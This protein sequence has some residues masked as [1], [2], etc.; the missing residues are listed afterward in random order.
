MSSQQSFV[1]YVINNLIIIATQLL[2]IG[3]ILFDWIDACYVWTKKEK[4][5]RGCY[6]NCIWTSLPLNYIKMRKAF[7]ILKKIFVRTV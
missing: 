1:V 3:W 4:K 5:I 7:Q 6:Y 2:L